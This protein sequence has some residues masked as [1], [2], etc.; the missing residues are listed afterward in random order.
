ML[1]VRGFVR[2]AVL[3]DRNK[4]LG[5]SVKVSLQFIIFYYATAD[6]DLKRSY[7]KAG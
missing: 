6:F 1:E 7:K 3:V 2:G 4:W 5:V